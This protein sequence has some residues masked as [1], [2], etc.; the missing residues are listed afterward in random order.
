ML[1][2]FLA[3]PEAIP[4]AF[5]LLAWDGVGVHVPQRWEIGRHEGRPLLRLTGKRRGLAPIEIQWL[6]PRHRRIPRQIDIIWDAAAN[7]IYCIELLRTSPDM[8]PDVEAL[9]RSMRPM[10]EVS[11]GVGE[12]GRTVIGYTV[13][14]P[15]RLRLLRVLGG[16]PAGKEKQQRNLELDLIGTMVWEEC[17]RERRVCDIIDRVRARFRISYRGAELS[18]TELIRALGSRG[19]LAVTLE[20][21]S[22]EN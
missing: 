13:E 16:F 6:M 2:F 8:E 9:E 12:N 21:P 1:N 10:P 20:P 14:R 5:K 3:S 11:S 7:K 15:R 18:V 4:A 19:L 17:G 22:E